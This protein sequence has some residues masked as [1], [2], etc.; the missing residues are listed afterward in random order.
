MYKLISQFWNNEASGNEIQ[1]RNMSHW[2]FF[3]LICGQYATGKRT[4]TNSIS[5]LFF[6][7]WSLVNTQ[8]VNLIQ[9]QMQIL[10]YFHIHYLILIIQTVDLI[11][12]LCLNLLFKH[13]W[14]IWWKK[15][16]YLTSTKNSHLF[17]K[18][19]SVEKWM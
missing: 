4:N 2:L 10:H 7:S 12:I 5:F 1:K 19:T 13:N 9:E 16:S 15:N 11:N 14:K 6:S 8:L 17:I 18:I 3:F